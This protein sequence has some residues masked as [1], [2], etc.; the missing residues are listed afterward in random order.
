MGNRCKRDLQ[1][2]IH[3]LLQN[4]LTLRMQGLKTEEESQR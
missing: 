4:A 2:H 3:N 1:S